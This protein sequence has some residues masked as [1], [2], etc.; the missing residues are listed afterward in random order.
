MLITLKKKSSISNHFIG[1]KIFFEY[2]N[3]KN[4]KK[5][6]QIGS[7]SE[8]GKIPSPQKVYIV[9]EKMTLW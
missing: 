2:F 9:K 5:F 3:E 1:V 8:Y 7:S 4:I 6:I